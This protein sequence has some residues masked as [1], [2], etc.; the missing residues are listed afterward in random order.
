MKWLG[1]TDPELMILKAAIGLYAA[2]R[3]VNRKAMKALLA[4]LDEPRPY[5]EITVGVHG[6]LVQWVL[7]NPFPIRIRDYDGDGRELPDVDEEGQRCSV[8]L[9]PADPKV[10]LRGRTQVQG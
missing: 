10:L 1:L 7:G 5:P 3:R 2:D 9:E 8:W 6:G 4:K